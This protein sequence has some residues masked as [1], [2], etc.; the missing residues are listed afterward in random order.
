MAGRL[1]M[2]SRLQFSVYVVQRGLQIDFQSG[3]EL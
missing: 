1:S 2:L 3:A